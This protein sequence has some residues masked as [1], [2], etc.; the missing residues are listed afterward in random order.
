MCASSF[1]R[2]GV[3]AMAAATRPLASALA[4]AAAELDGTVFFSEASHLWAA[5][6]LSVVAAHAGP[7]FEKRAPATLELAFALLNSPEA[8]DVVDGDVRLDAVST[9]TEE[10]RGK[11][12][13]VLDSVNAS[14]AA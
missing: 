3:L 14:R 12:T 11:E 9:E 13:G 1:R 7:A 8:N 6:A 10:T 5:H 4:V 2:A